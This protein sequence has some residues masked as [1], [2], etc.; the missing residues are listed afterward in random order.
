VAGAE[1]PPMAWTS[2]DKPAAG[3]KALCP[4]D[5]NMAIAGPWSLST[6]G[7]A[8]RLMSPVLQWLLCTALPSLV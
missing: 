4:C 7:L 6:S 1:R 5:G 8:P 3:A 2:C